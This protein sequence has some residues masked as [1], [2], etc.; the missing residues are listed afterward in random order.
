MAREYA[1]R[2]W[3]RESEAL[4]IKPQPLL[5]LHPLDWHERALRDEN[6]DGQGKS[7]QQESDDS[8]RMLGVCGVVMVFAVVVACWVVL[9]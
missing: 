3:R 6:Y 9:R 2:V 4:M 5:R 7:Q 8:L 1:A